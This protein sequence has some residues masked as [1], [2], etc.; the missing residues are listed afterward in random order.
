MSKRIKQSAVRI[1]SKLP[2]EIFIE[3][4]Q[5]AILLKAI[6]GNCIIFALYHSVADRELVIAE[7]KKRF[8][9]KIKELF[10]SDKRKDV[11]GLLTSLNGRK[12]NK[13]GGIFLYELEKTFPESLGNLNLQREILAEVPQPLVFWIREFALREIAEKAPD[14]W[15]WRTEV[16][17]FRLNKPELAAP[18]VR[19]Y[20][21]ERSFYHKTREDL[22]R[23][24]HLF[25]ELLEQHERE[26]APDKNMIA[27]LSEK[28]AQMHYYLSDFDLAW[29]YLE[30]G[31]NIYQELG[32]RAGL[33]KCYGNQ[34]LILQA[35]GRL[36]EAMAL[37]KKIE[38]IFTELG[39]RAGLART[40]WNQ[41]IIYGKKGDKKRQI[42]L[43]RKAIATNKAIGIPTEEDERALA[44][45]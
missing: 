25:Q 21:S 18:T 28:L 30:K 17:D 24:I 2:L 7:L 42:E 22:D 36:D 41:G 39:D 19:A 20:L 8:Q 12:L 27:Y 16:F 38:Q 32:D 26:A 40:W 4:D 3:I 1:A 33:A 14:F 23:R 9:G 29:K 44:E 15:A 43:W 45:L 35:W 6:K 34:A 13:R 31:L 37:F 11:I 10:F 5:L